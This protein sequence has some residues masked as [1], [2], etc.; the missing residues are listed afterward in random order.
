[1]EAI[2]N[3]SSSMDTFPSSG[4]DT[5]LWQKISTVAKFTL[6]GMLTITCFVINPS[7]FWASF[8]IGVAFHEKVKETVDNIILMMKNQKLLVIPTYLAAAFF[9]LP[10]TI[11]ASTALWG[12][13]L[14]T[15]FY[16]TAA[17]T[18]QNLIAGMKK[19]EGIL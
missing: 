18:E 3:A 4:T 10:V 9:A 2:Q 14:G 17:E 5:T 12:S 7:I 1:M 13:F 11:A 8:I 19:L 16:Y 15:H 6:A